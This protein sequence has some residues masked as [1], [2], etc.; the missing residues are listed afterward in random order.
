MAE[1]VCKAC[2][3]EGTR[4]KLLRG[5]KGMEIFIW[6]V[7]M[8]PG[9]L[10]S[11]WRRTG[12]SNDCRHCGLPMLVPL[13]SDI[14]QLT[15]LKF[16]RELGI[17]VPSEAKKKDAPEPFGKTIIPAATP[18]VM[19]EEKPVEIAEVTVKKPVNPNQW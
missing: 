1:W 2:G 7:L 8:V 9:P 3:W 5:S 4:K 19:T 15:R 6:S 18:I 13:D 11:I 17:G 10:Y 14:G 12:K 16:D